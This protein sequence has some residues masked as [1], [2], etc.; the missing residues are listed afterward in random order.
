MSPQ[1]FMNPKIFLAA[2][3]ALAIAVG[4]TVPPPGKTAAEARSAVPTLEAGRG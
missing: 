3:A 1:I 2:A 4:L